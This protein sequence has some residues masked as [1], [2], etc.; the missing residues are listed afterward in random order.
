MCGELADS[1]NTHVSIGAAIPDRIS[2]YRHIFRERAELTGGSQVVSSRI[3]SPGT[4]VGRS[5]YRHHS[6][7]AIWAA[8]S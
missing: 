3:H 7:N 6:N 8:K 1:L 2:K 5:F 4:A